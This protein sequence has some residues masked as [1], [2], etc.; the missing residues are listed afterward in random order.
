MEP[1]VFDKQVKFHD[2]SL[3]RSR[4]IPPEADRGCIFDC[5]PY[6]FRLEVGND[7]ISGV[8]V[9][10]FGTDTYVKFGDSRSNSFRDIRGA[11]SPK[12]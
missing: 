12:T 1:L 6:N 5:F 3:N 8:A 11:D 4:E 7:V 9:D 2:P 10:N